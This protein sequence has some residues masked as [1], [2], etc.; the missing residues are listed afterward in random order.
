MLSI[1]PSKL[2]D[3]LTCAHKFKLKHIVKANKFSAS[4]A[5]AF[6]SSMHAALQKFHDMDRL[7][8]NLGEVKKVLNQKWDSSAYGSKEEEGNYFSKGCVALEN[9]CVAQTG[10]VEETLGTEIFMSF[11]VPLK[12]QQIRLG[13][14]TDRLA[15]LPDKTLLIIDY[16]TN[17]SGKL[18]TPEF[19]ANDLATFLYYVLT[20]LSYPQYP[21]L[22]IKF[23]NVMT[24]TSVLIEYDRA[25]I[26]ANKQALWNCL[27]AL[28]NERFVPHASEA[29]AWCDFQDDCPL[30]NKIGDFSLI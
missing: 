19:L 5:F 26:D 6:G 9:Y 28:P 18:P 3:Y 17:A 1:T 2:T 25:Q 13:C 16:K 22:K 29:C 24:L 12:D 20:R 11:I 8:Q 30:T 23:L 7:P 27:R 14:K 15:L 10:S 4:K 21:N